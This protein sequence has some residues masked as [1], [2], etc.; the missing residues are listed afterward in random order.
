MK[1]LDKI[2]NMLVGCQKHG[3][4]KKQGRVSPFLSLCFAPLNR[5]DIGRGMGARFKKRYFVLRDNILCY[6]KGK[7]YAEVRF[8]RVLVKANIDCRISN[9]WVSFI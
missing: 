3:L 4:L 9:L 1:Q 6:Y 7:T 5:Y 8:T 2:R